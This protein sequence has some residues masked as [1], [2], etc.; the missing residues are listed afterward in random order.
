MDT[1]YIQ[2]YPGEWVKSVWSIIYQFPDPDTGFADF[3]EE[4]DLAIDVPSEVP[5]WCTDE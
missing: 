3:C 4:C 1:V 2:S 5:S